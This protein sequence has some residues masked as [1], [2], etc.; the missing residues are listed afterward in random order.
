MKTLGI[1]GLVISTLFGLI[2]TGAPTDSK[3]APTTAT[4]PAQASASGNALSDEE[5]SK[6]TSAIDA[7]FE[8]RDARLSQNEKS[9]EELKNQGINLE[10]S[11]EE[12]NKK[13]A[14]AA[15]QN[16]ARFKSIEQ[17]LASMKTEITTSIKDAI[18]E[19]FAAEKAKEAPVVP[20]APSTGAPAETTLAL[21]TPEVEN[22]RAAPEKAV[23]VTASANKVGINPGPVKNA[24]GA[25]LA[26]R[27]NAGNFYAYADKAGTLRDR[28]P[29]NLSGKMVWV[30]E[31]GT[32][33][34]A[35]IAQ[36]SYSNQYQ[37]YTGGQEYTPRQTYSYE[38]NY[39]VPSYGVCYGGNCG[40]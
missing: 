7:K 40:G 28:T 16:D 32:Y 26:F 14:E 27:C 11:I 3:P 10:G 13:I 18:R 33:T 19:Q 31:D 23:P 34:E 30:K 38:Q 21:N 8:E 17:S 6:I 4:M 37:D 22:T 36:P 15:S 35:Y 2:S 9:I 20:V 39:F 29:G 12:I 25:F 1:S 5:I 24:E